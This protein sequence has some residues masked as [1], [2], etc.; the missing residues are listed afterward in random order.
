MNTV[1][2]SWALAVGIAIV[3]SITPPSIAA[4]VPGVTKDEIK[5]GAFGPFAGPV[6][7]YG[8][9]T[10]NG[11]D[12]LFDKVNQQG[13]VHGRKLR[14]VREDDNCK[15]E[16]AIVAVKKL[17]YEDKVF[18]INGGACS[19]STLAAKPEIVKAGIPLVVNSAVADGISSPPSPTIYTTQ[20][21]ATI[22]SRAQVKY[23]IEQRAK[24]VAV[25]AQRD[26]WGRARYEP[27]MAALKDQRITPVAD[28]EMTVDQNDATAQAL[29]LSSAGAD[30][31]LLVVYPKP[32]AVLIRDSVKLGYKPAWVGQTAIQDLPQL[33]EQVGIPQ[34]LDRFVSISTVP[35]TPDDPEMAEWKQR[36]QRLFPN[37]ALSVFN[38]M[39]IGSGMVVVE[40]LKRAGPDL[41]REK[42]L[43]ALGTIKNFK[44]GIFPGPITC[45]P[46]TSHQCNQSVAWIRLVDGTVKVVGVTTV[47]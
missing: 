37:D 34:G 19:N 17:I 5:I 28:E 9:L 13:G 24:K 3:A 36:I 43:Q 42:F 47:E 40:A 45:N 4:D 46:P 18:A 8:R 32:A 39:G 7:M 10:M 16:D 23:A 27:L 21:T 35:G 2:K 6:Y 22:E 26:A 15:P 12:A 11:L 1:V 20:L 29:R 44:T 41:T 33:Q 14:L 25:V 30:V 31:V 38:L